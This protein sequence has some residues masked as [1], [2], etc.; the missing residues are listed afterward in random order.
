MPP[1]KSKNNTP[2]VEKVKGKL[3][4]LQLTYIYPQSLI[5][6]ETDY[7]FYTEI[8]RLGRRDQGWK[9]DSAQNCAEVC[10][11]VPETRIQ[12]CKLLALLPEGHSRIEEVW[13][14]IYV[15]E[16][17]AFQEIIRVLTTLVMNCNYKM[18]TDHQT[19]N[20]YCQSFVLSCFLGN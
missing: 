10:G 3:W 16:G 5:M 17:S 15:K 19:I 11:T 20:V 6:T 9:T 2:Y 12:S 13:F 14:C 8:T 18:T 1:L 7:I 4:H